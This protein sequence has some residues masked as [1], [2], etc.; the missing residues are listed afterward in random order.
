MPISEGDF[1]IRLIIALVSKFL[2]HAQLQLRRIT[3]RKCTRTSAASSG[4]LV[5]LSKEVP[6]WHLW[7]RQTELPLVWIRDA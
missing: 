4:N 2:L 5:I 1:S 6:L 7:V 3:A